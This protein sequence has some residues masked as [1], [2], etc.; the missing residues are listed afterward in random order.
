MQP[1]D[2]I[3]QAAQHLA[4]GGLHVQRQRDHVVDHNMRRQIALT[5]T[6]LPGRR[7]NR[8]NLAHREGFGDHTKADVIGDPAATGKSRNGTCHLPASCSITS[9]MQ[10][11]G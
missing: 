10:N 6:G 3:Q 2:A 1:L 11:Y 4:I 7:Q 5:D 9:R 8:V